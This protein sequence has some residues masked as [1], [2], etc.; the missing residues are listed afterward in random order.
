MKLHFK[1]VTEENRSLVLTLSP[2]PEQEGF[3]ENVSQCLWEADHRKSWRPVGIYDEDLLVGFAMYGFFWEYLP[4]GRVWLDRLLIDRKF[5]GRGYGKAALAGLTDLLCRT[6]HRKKI[7]LSIIDGNEAALH[8]YEAF[9]YRFTGKKDLH[10]ERIMV[11]RASSRYALI[12][13]ADCPL[14]TAP[15]TPPVD[16]DTL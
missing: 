15:H 11:Y 3:I 13:P 10:G 5:Q 4:F 7:Y 14:H 9:G 1:P 16:S 6:Y 12:T 2:A 8:L